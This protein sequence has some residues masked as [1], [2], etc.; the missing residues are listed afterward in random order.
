MS[1]DKQ[2]GEEIEA[3]AFR[4]AEAILKENGGKGE[5]LPIFHARDFSGVHYIIATPWPD[6]KDKANA[7]RALKLMFI[8]KRI[9]QYAMIS[10]A[11]VRSV[12]KEGLQEYLGAGKMVSEYDDKKEVVIVS[13]TSASGSWVNQKE[14]LRDSD[15]RFTKL[16]PSPCGDGAKTVGGRMTELLPPPN[17]PP[18]PEII[19]AE[20]DKVWEQMSMRFPEEVK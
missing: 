16:G 12:A 2:F 10:E 20:L 6:E 14:I 8:A 17:A 19:R 15:G 4:H 11:W 5:L 3:M 9:V 13:V 1:T 7:L 18:I